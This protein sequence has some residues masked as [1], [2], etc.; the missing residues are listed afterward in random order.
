MLI[1]FLHSWQVSMPTFLISVQRKTCLLPAFL[2][3]KE[4]KKKKYTASHENLKLTFSAM[5]L[6]SFS[7]SFSWALA[8]FST[9]VFTVSHSTLQHQIQNYG[10]QHCLSL[11][12]KIKSG[13]RVYGTYVGKD[14][15]HSMPDIILFLR[16]WRAN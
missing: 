8:T 10:I 5:F 13:M 6:D 16:M 3:K 4:K 15:G 11:K 12:T 14:T 1:G 7:G 9:K 2:K